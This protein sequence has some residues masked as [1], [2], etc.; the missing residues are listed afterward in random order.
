MGKN[1]NV[2]KLTLMDGMGNVYP[3][4]YFGNAEEM[5]EFL[6]QADRISI[7]YYPE[8]NR[9]MGREEIQFVISHYC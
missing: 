5:M 3:A 8:I 1:R 9:Y 4:V 7:V 6:E 2:V